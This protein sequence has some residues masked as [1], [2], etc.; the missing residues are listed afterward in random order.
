M[1]LG[2][3]VRMRHGAGTG[4]VLRLPLVRTGRALRQFP[5]EAEQV[6]EE[7]VAPLRGRGGPGDFQAAGDRVAA[8]AGA[9]AA[10]PAE[11]LLLDAGGFGLR[12]H[13]GRRAGAMGLAEGMAA[14]D[15]GD[16][17]FVIHRHAGKSLAD[18][19]RRSDRIGI[20]VR[21]FGIDVNQA[22]LHCGER[23]LQVARVRLLAVS[24]VMTPCPGTP[25]EPCA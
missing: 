13:M 4:A 23:I 22:H 8:F 6:P 19:A 5:F 14:R 25:G 3:V 21:T 20:A 11:A 2:R 10:F 15:Q 17:F 18:V 7:I 1:P 24:S 16:G 9:E 12:P